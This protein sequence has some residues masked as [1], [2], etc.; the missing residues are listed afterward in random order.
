MPEPTEPKLELTSG[1]QYA[2]DLFLSGKSMCITGPAGCGKSYLIKYIKQYCNQNS[3][4][5][6]ITALT[7]AAATIVGGS[8]IHGWGGL[9]LAKPDA[10]T[11]AKTIMLKRYKAKKRWLK[12]AVL[13]IDEIS[14]MSA[15]L[16]NKINKVGQIIRNNECFMGGIQVILSGDFLQLEPI[17]SDKFCFETN[18]WKTYIA[19]TVVYMD[20]ILR[21]SDPI[22]QNMLSE[23][24][25]GNVTTKTKQLLEDRIIDDKDDVSIEIED[26]KEKIIP[27]VLYPH[28]IAVERENMMEYSKLVEA[29]AESH[30]YHSNDVMYNKSSKMASSLTKTEQTILDNVCRASRELELCVGAQV[31]LIWNMD[32]P[33]GLVNGSRG[34]ITK[35]DQGRPVVVYDNGREV[36]TEKFDFE[37]DIGK[38]VLVRKQ[39]P[40]ML[41]WALTIHKCQGATLTHVIADLSKCFCNAQSYVTL[42]R[43]RDMEGL[44][45]SAIDFKRIKAN[46]KVVKYYKLLL[47]NRKNQSRSEEPVV[48]PLSVLRNTIVS[49]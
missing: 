24:R 30:S 38:E 44:F 3:I 1:Q 6:G 43:V 35:F 34:V 25:V 39:F 19:D 21:Q 48:H 11:I 26:E 14:M 5:I 46:R 22:F 13:I 41:A 32:V 33:A 29:G 16:F 28:K 2:F 17:G 36:K 42:S 8:T 15:E 40:L 27:T 45:L 18:I 20:K 9:R 31:M 12:T 10:R 37:V 23:I 49:T 47:Q 4:S 7:G